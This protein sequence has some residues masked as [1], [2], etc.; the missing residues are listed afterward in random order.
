MMDKLN[1][2]YRLLIDVGTDSKPEVVEITDPLTIDFIINRGIFSSLNTGMFKIYNLASTTRTKIFQDL[3]R[4]KGDSLLYKGITLQAGYNQLSTIFKGNLLQSFSFRKG[5][6]I[7]QQIEALDGI[8]GQQNS[9]TNLTLG[10][11]A[12]FNEALDK[13]SK[14]FVNLDRG[15]FSSFD[16]V[17]KKPFSLFGDSLGEIKKFMKGEA[18]VFVDNEKV[19]VLKRNEGVVGQIQ[20]IN[21][22][23]GLLGT[24]IRRNTFLEVEMIFEPRLTIGQ[25]VEIKSSV[26]P[27]YDG[28]YKIVGITHA[29]TISGA[30]SGN[31]KTKL[32]LF[33]GTEL[34]EG[35]KTISGSL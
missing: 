8:F 20:L 12:T 24:P 14:D 9:F 19:S 28:Q 3:Y 11:G 30:V 1:R 23:T 25:F 18:E 16:K 2:R 10:K 13:V 26:N 32:Q 6:D 29:G 21:S 31:S 35:L 34:T 15:V 7:I 33:I 27:V 5:A 22:E 4:L 17:F